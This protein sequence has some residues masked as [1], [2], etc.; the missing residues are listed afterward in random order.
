MRHIERI[1]WLVPAISCLVMFPAATFT[2]RIGP[3][4][5]P[6]VVMV[7]SLSRLT[8]ANFVGHLRQPRVPGPAPVP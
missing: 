7:C 2:L 4:Q 8:P 6:T 3:W 5:M 1:S